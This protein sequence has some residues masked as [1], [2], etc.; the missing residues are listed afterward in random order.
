[1]VPAAS[2]SQLTLVD[3]ICALNTLQTDTVLHLVKEVV[4]RPPQVRG[5]EKSPLVD[6]PVLQFCYA[7]IQSILGLKLIVSQQHA[8]RL[9]NKN[10]Q[11]GEQE[12]SKRFAEAVGNIAGSSLEQTSWLSRNLEVKAQPQISLEESDDEEDL[13]ADAAAAAS[14]MVSA[15]APSVY[16]VQALSLLA[17][18]LA[19]LLD[20]VYRSDEKEKAVPLISRLLY[21]VFP[22]LRNHSAYNAPSFRA[23]AQLLSSLSGYAYTKRAWKKEVLELFLDPAFFQMDTSCVQ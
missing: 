3:L 14:A 8:E 21:Y 7:F 5:D 2:A 6:V 12:G 4:K 1:M 9:R 18:V 15:S 17:E 11:P 23:G 13:H 10:S 19:S 22:Y 16:S 20:M